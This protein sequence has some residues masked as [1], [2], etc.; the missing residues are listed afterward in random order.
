MDVSALAISAFAVLTAWA[1]ACLS[2]VK[3]G[4]MRLRED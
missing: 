3:A 4:S 1:T 2:L